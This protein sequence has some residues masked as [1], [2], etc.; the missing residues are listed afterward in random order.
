MAG[1]NFTE[2]ERQHLLASS[3]VLDVSP[4][5]AHFSAAFKQKFCEALLDGKKPR[6]IVSELGLDPIARIS[7]KRF[8]LAHECFRIRLVLQITKAFACAMHRLHPWSRPIPLSHTNIRLDHT[9]LESL[10]ITLN[11]RNHHLLLL[12]SSTLIN[13]LFLT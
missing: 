7:V 10:P 13:A 6:D 8:H 2:D 9:V 12:H 1:K 3:Y 5:I 11:S 4:T